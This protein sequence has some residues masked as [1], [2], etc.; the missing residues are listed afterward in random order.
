[1]QIF[2]IKDLSGHGKAGEIINVNEGYGRNFVIKNGF[3]RIVN[4]AIATEIHA[5]MASAN[6]HKNQ[7]IAEIKKVIDRLKS[8]RVSVRATIGANGK[9]FGGITGQ[10][11]CAELKNLGFEIDKKSLSFEPIKS[12]GEYIIKVKFNHGLACEFVLNVVGGI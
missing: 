4:K 3:G 8:V 11:I 10:E 6:F 7:E 5:Q 9:M 1:M 12:A 2:L